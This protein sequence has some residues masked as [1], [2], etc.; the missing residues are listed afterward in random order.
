MDNSASNI[1]LEYW[2]VEGICV[3]GAGKNE[4][5]AK[6][7]K[8]GQIFIIC[9]LCQISLS[10]LI[11]YDNWKACTMRLRDKMCMQIVIKNLKTGD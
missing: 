8:Y 10:N 11:K 1:Q 2:R 5:K 3:L 6:I 9:K 4:K 7:S